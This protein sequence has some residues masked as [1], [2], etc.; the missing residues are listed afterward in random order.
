MSN[1]WVRVIEERPISLALS[2]RIGVQHQ[3]PQAL[4][5]KDGKA[6]WNDSHHNITAAALKDAVNKA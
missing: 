2:E 6:V 4:L 3:S 5:I 1:A